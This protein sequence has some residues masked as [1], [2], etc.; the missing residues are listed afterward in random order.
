MSQKMTIGNLDRILV[1]DDT[2]ANLQLLTNVLTEHGYTV[3]PASDGELALRFVRSILPDIILLDIRMPG[4]DGYD[5]CRRLKADERTRSIPII[6]I[7]ILEDERDKVKGF[8]A[9]AVDYITKPFQPEEVLA[10]VRTHLRVQ[11]LT[12]RLEQE[13]R[14]RTE[15]LATTNQQLLQELAERR[16]TEALLRE[17]EEK[18]RRLIQRIQAAVVVYGA[19]TRVLTSN[20]QAQQL[21]GLT[22]EQMFGKA[23]IDPDWRIFRE[24]GTDIPLE[25]YPVRRVLNSGES[26]RNLVVGV[27]RPGAQEDVWVLISADPVLDDN[28]KMTQVIMTFV[29]ITA[30]KR[31]EQKR[32]E[33]EERLRLTLE[34]TQIGIFDWDLEHDIWYASPE[35]FTML[36]YEPEDG[37]GDRKQWLKRVHPD[38]RGHVEAK[39][40]EV[41][42][43]DCSADQ[44]LE[45]KYEARMRH[46]DGTYRWEYV[47]GFGIKRDQQGRLTRMLGIRMDITDR[48]AAE[49]MLRKLN[50]EL[51]RR[52]LER[53]AELEA[54][55]KEMHAFTYTVSHDLRA[56]LRHIDG[57][58]ELLQKKAGT[59]LDEQ[60][61]HYMDAISEAANKM[62]LLIDDLLSFTYM[63]RHVL[64]FQPV[65]LE[66]LVRDV[67]G[68][69]EPDAAG[70][71]IDWRIGH[72][73]VVRCDAAMLRM[74][75]A[76]LIAN[77]LKF[78]RPR[79]QARIEVGSLPSQ[80]AEAVIFVRDN[81]VGFDMAYVDKLFGIFQ[82]LHRAE[83]FE[84]T[85]IGLANVRRIITMHGGRTWAE[86]KPNQGATIFFAMPVKVQGDGELK[87]HSVGG[88]RS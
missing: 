18:Y 45:Y 48:K 65:D 54:A 69:F 9:G 47:K 55:N 43:G 84:G 79:Q 70:R 41:L 30:R 40:R 14:E 86:G 15:E 36:G 58:M 74:V 37:I 17:S 85:G 62:G 83:E 71:D 63:G 76:N 21:L 29:D 77:A 28:G 3:H 16:R 78:T 20:L 33:S 5:V 11:K 38:D 44:L 19:D 57:F 87:E 75:M 60:G 6:F 39:I 1:V 49:E 88:G 51:D 50:T 31:A 52:V 2:T 10:R 81:G 12:E 56:P 80:D 59:T 61:R 82:R 53:T 8:Q 66:S 13:V 26:L 35:Y 34:A 67:I 23:A 27:H 32:Q 68:E 46:A 4:M 7:S 73:P 25:E 72:L 64:S 24:D 22:Q 42:A